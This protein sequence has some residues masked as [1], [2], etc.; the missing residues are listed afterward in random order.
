TSP[1]VTTLHRQA[2]SA[3]QNA[4]DI[5]R[6]CAHQRTLAELEPGD[7]AVVAAA[8]DCWNVLLGGPRGPEQVATQKA[9]TPQLRVE[10]TCDAG[11]PAGD[12]P[13]PVV[14]APDGGV[15]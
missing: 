10:V 1:L 3:F 13:A 15:T 14:V 5:V 12:C 6:A 2:L 9:E 11:T 4:G 7:S 8:L